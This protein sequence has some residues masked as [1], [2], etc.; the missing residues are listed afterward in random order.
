MACIDDGVDC[1]E[2]L[3]EVY[4]YLHEELDRERMEQVR[5]HLE[6]CGHCLQ[7]YGLE[8]EVQTLIARSCGCST[9]PEALRQRIVK[10]ITEIRFSGRGGSDPGTLYSETTY[11]QTTWSETYSETTWS[12]TSKNVTRS[13][14][15]HER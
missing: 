10:R 5:N 6:R 11:S 12:E 4:E 7:Q 8:Q 3:S 2:V 14:L 9:A 15:D 1:D 13:P